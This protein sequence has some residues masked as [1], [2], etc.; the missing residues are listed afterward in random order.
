MRAPVDWN[1]RRD[2][3]CKR[4]PAYNANVVVDVVVAVV[5]IVV[6]VIVVIVMGS[7]MRIRGLFGRIAECRWHTSCASDKQTNVPVAYSANIQRSNV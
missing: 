3:I 1:V 6:V 5:V 2:A 7:P 4:D